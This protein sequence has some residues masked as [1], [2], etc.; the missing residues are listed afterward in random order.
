[1]KR[2]IGAFWTLL[3]SYLPLTAATACYAPDGSLI[4]N[5]IYQPCISIPGVH[6][7]CC[8]LNSVDP[9][10]C[11]PTGLCLTSGG[12]YYREFCTD[13]SWN[14]TNC[15]PKDICSDQ[16]GGNSDR[17]YQLTSCGE[18]LWCCG[19]STSCCNTHETFTLSPTLLN[20]DLDPSSSLSATAAPTTTVTVVPTEGSSSNKGEP[21][22]LTKVAIG[23]GVGVPLA[24]IAVGM[25]G[26]G[27]L[28]GRRS[29]QKALSP[30]K[31]RHRVMSIPLEKPKGEIGCSHW[32][33]D[34]ASTSKCLEIVRS[35]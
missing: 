34:A 8:R 12:G 14:S 1:M 31:P 24:C 30:A 15:L 25:L 4:A 35:S 10:K 27:C 3:S 22:M 21:Q 18:G 6:S 33:D 29:T 28:L 11:D 7:M 5:S 17:T 26:V 19:S 20:F 23:V 13:Q 2:H 32:S 16:N 9:D